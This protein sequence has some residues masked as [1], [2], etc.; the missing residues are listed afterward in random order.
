MADLAALHR[1]LLR[2][3]EWPVNASAVAVVDVNGLVASRGDIEQV[4]ALASITKLVTALSMLVA[5][6]EGTVSWT[7]LVTPGITLANLMSHSA[8]VRPEGVG[9]DESIS[10]AAPGTRRIYSNAGFEMAAAHLVARSRI[11]FGQY[12]AEAV[13]DPLELSL[14][15][16]AGQAATGAPW[17]T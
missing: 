6:E 17:A 11:P 1:A 5:V 12:V 3:D 8:G 4:F 16:L 13:L 7:D 14:T 9:R 2:I 15:S 10:V